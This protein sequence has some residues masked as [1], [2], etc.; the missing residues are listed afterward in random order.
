M[1]RYLNVERGRDSGEGWTVG[2]DRNRQKKGGLRGL[3]G[4]LEGRGKNKGKKVRLTTIR[5]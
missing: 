3:R 2:R 1:E 4:E 5:E